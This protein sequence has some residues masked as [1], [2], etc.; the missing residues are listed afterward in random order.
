MGD[1]CPVY[2]DV[3]VI[4]KKSLISP[5][6]KI[7]SWT[8]LTTCLEPILARGLASIRLVNLSIVTSRWV[9]PLGAFLKVPKRSRPHTAKD[10]VMGMVW[11]SWAVVWICL[12]KYWHLL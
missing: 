3:V 11:S 10:H 12:A 9:K 8:K 1:C 4:I 5:K 2:P 6:R 7:M